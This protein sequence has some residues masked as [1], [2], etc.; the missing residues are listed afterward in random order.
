LLT[1]NSFADRASLNSYAYV[2]ARM[3]ND[4]WIDQWTRAIYVQFTLYNPPVHA[5]TARDTRCR[6]ICL[7]YVVSTSTCHSPAQLCRS[8]RA[9]LCVCWPIRYSISRDCW[10]SRSL[11]SCSCS[12]ADK[13]RTNVSKRGAYYT[14]SVPHVRKQ[15]FVSLHAQSRELHRLGVHRVGHTVHCRHGVYARGHR[16]GRAGARHVR[17]VRTAHSW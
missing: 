11:R 5:C 14:R 3:R 9:A 13:V 6:R 8:S 2:F 16:A 4:T 12:L 1:Y 15:M 10:R 7:E 17:R